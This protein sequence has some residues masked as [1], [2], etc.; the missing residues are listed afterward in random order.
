M[1]S[2]TREPPGPVPEKSE[3]KP[4]KGMVILSTGGKSKEQIKK[5]VKDAMRKAGLL[6]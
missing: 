1:K 6:K 3:D 5:E 4:A 2:T